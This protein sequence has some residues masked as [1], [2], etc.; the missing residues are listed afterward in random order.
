[1]SGFWKEA[2][3]RRKKAVVPADRIE[4]VCSSRGIANLFAEMFSSITETDAYVT[5]GISC[6]TEIGERRTVISVRDLSSDYDSMV[7]MPITSSFSMTRI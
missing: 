7:H 4:D 3:S 5:E 2:K 6:S 1:M